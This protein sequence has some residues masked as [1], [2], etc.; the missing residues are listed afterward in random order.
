MQRTLSLNGLYST[1]ACPS[2]YLELLR[3]FRIRIT[4]SF[5]YFVFGFILISRLRFVSVPIN[6]ERQHLVAAQLLIQ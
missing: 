5:Y 6:R 3:Y 4:I 2:R 1:L